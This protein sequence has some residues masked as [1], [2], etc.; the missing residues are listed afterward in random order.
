MKV[1]ILNGRKLML[2]SIILILSVIFAVF[3]TS[4]LV[5]QNS[6]KKIPIYSVE[7]NDNKIAL[8]FNCAWG[9]E[10][11]GQIL[12]I[13]KKHNVKS[14]FFVVGKW[15][16]KYPDDLKLIASEGHEIGSHSYNHAHYQ[17]MSY[18]EILA[19]M[20]KCDSVMENIL[21]RDIFYVRGGYGEY[22]DDV[23]TACENSKRTYIQW[24]VDS[25]D[26]KAKS[27]DDI[28]NRV[29]SKT[30]NGDI[31]LMHTGTEYTV[32]ALDN[33]LNELCKSYE[34]VSVSDLIYT[35]HYTIDHSGKQILT[36]QNKS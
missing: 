6:N 21:G 11:I 28:L 18:D 4:V 1:F 19:D 35:E 14:T 22:N 2:L 23:L 8:T 5:S 12:E 31:I 32:K 15:A 7:R 30:V 20:E 36:E 34:C 24:S 26:Y 29:I 3:N 27:I 17:K 13:L 10:D 33:L 9:N 16:E 25:L